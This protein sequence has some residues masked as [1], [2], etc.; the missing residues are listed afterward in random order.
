MKSPEKMTRLR[1]IKRKNLNEKELT[2]SE[3]KKVGT[4][5]KSK[6]T[7]KQVRAAMNNTNSSIE[8]SPEK[9]TK[10]DGRRKV[11]S[12]EK[13]VKV[14]G[15]KKKPL[16]DLMKSL[17]GVTV[18]EKKKIVVPKELRAKKGTTMVDA[19]NGK[20]RKAT[21]KLDGRTTRWLN[22]RPKKRNRPLSERKNWA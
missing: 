22:K 13:V 21:E 16:I 20:K 19:K 10:V 3:I 5:K 6:I 8:S 7:A 14:D 2:K 1:P 18:S 15:R 4:P 9:V 12:V 11:E 17:K